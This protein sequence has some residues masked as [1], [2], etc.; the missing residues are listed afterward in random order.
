MRSKKIILLVDND[1][2]FA[3]E[4]QA[5]LEEYGYDVIT[6]QSGEAALEIIKQDLWID[7]ILMEIFPGDGLDGVETAGRILKSRNIPLIFLTSHDKKLIIEKTAAIACYGCLSKDTK[8]E[9]IDAS[10]TI[11]LN[12]FNSHRNLDE[13]RLLSHQSSQVGFWERDLKTDKILCSEN[14][15][16]MFGLSSDIYVN[17]YSFFLQCIHPDDRMRIAQEITAALEVRSGFTLEY[18]IIHPDGNVRWFTDLARVFNDLEGKP[19][20]L[21]GSVRD[22]TSQ[23]LMEEDIR[24]NRANLI[25]LIENMDGIIWS[26]DSEYRLVTG[27]TAFHNLVTMIRGKSFDPGDNV[28]NFNVPDEII[29][30]WQ[31]YYNRA[32]KGEGFSIE[33]HPQLHEK[34]QV[35]EYRFNP[36]IDAKGHIEGATVFGRNITEQKE[37]EKLLRNSEARYKALY[38]KA[39]L[40][41]QS[42]DEN[43]YFL[44]VNPAWLKAL[45]YERDEVIGNKFADFLHPDWFGIYEKNFPIFKKQGYISDVHMRL[46]HK[47]GDYID[48]LFEGCIGFTPEGKVKQTYCVFVD[49]TEKKLAHEEIQ[50]QLREKEM[51]LKEVHHRIKNHIA[52]IA[53]I[54]SIQAK[55]ANNEETRDILDNTRGRVESI[56]LLYDKLLF[57]EKYKIIDIKSYL[58]GLIDSIIATTS[59]TDKV[60]VE[61][62][63]DDFSIDTK[64]LFPLAV[65]LNELLTN[66]MKH[67]FRENADGVIHVVLKHHHN[68]VEL[69]VH[70]NGPGLPKGLDLPD[71]SAFGLKLVRMLA[72]QLKGQFTIQNNQGTECILVFNL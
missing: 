24:K 26:I 15:A 66:A 35:Y 36:V 57:S 47:I 40:P 67:A 48:V 59:Q 27:N 56:R 62:Q 1:S 60:I 49:I 12:L 25:A 11:A 17:D 61:K 9:F 4:K 64:K 39:P 6:A 53:S 52:N 70:D 22:V 29:N 13:N 42:L 41:Y 10:I 46:K 31:E 54:L 19:H 30:K 20:R 58:D 34:S 32:F 37:A 23:K 18:R 28:L 2:H 33:M 44:D 72:K 7:L 43:G 65:I 38:E 50:R 69:I 51:L 45:G 3:M 63:I 5:A 68:Q 8:V 14:V 71:I 55:T 21:V 16:R